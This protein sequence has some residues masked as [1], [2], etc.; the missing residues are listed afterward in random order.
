VQDRKHTYAQ[1]FSIYGLSAYYQAS[2]NQKSLALAQQLFEL[3]ESH[4]YDAVNGG[5]MECRARDWSS[6]AD[7]R[8]SDKDINS[9]RSMNTLLHLMEA[10]AA[11]FTLWPDKNLKQKLEGLLRVFLNHIIDMKNFHLR[12]F[13]DDHWNSL[14]DH[15]S[16]GH[17]IETSWLFLESAETLGDPDLI[18]QARTISIKMA[19]SVYDE[20]LGRDGSILYET[21]QN[22]FRIS[23]RQWWTHAE[24][25]IGFYNAYQLSGEAHFAEASARVWKYIQHHFVDKKDGD[26]FKHLEED[27]R[28]ILTQDKVGPWECPYHH[29]RMCFEMIKRIKEKAII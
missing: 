3:I 12:L 20:A 28:P 18:T 8:L 2:G 25:V 22:G 15:I 10:Y 26:W 6:L 23:T 19:Q 1:A 11:L 4:T 9:S 5:N 7:M 21:G 24:A 14:L 27:G 29:A 13:F 16:Y 17:D